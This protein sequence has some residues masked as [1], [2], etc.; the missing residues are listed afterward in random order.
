MQDMQDHSRISKAMRTIGLFWR[1]IRLVWDASPALTALTLALALLTAVTVPVQVWI[2]KV[3][4]DRIG[5]LIGQGEGGSWQGLMLPLALYIGVWGISQ[6]AQS[7]LYSVR[8]LLNKQTINHTQYRIIQKAA[9]LDAAFF[10][11][12][13]FYDQM[14]VAGREVWRLANIIYQGSGFIIFLV[15]M[16]SL[17]ILLGSI[18]PVLPAVLVLA[19]LPKIISEGHFTRKVSELMMR[20]VPEERMIDYV[21]ALLTERETV[22]EVRLFQLQ[23]HLLDRHRRACQQYFRSLAA[24][25]LS[26][27]RANS[28]FTLLSLISTAGIWVWAGVQALAGRISLGDI[29]LIF[30]SVERSRLSLD[31]IVIM[32]GFLVENTVYLNALFGYLDLEPGTVAGTLSRASD[33]GQVP[34][35]DL[36]GPIEFRGVS[37][38]YAGADRDALKDITFTIQPGEKVALVGENGAG[39]TTLV[40][41]LTRLYDPTAGEV[42]VNGR[43]LRS[44]DQARYYRRIGVIFQDFARYS[45]TAKEN[46]GLGCVEA[47]G[48]EDRIRRAARL[49][50]AAELIES[51]PHGYETMLN[52]RFEGGMDLSGGEWQKVALSRAF[53]RDAHLL[54]LDEPT[55]AL[56]A[57]A[58]SEV[59]QRFADLTRG[60]T[61]VFVTHRLSSVHMADKILVLKN[62]RLV[63][64]GN[65]DSLMALQGEYASMFN[66]QAEH[67]R[68]TVRDEA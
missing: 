42:T 10:D 65:H 2:S 44:L 43:D 45:L 49:G 57:F 51:L 29:A 37:F 19:A 30:Q 59:Y 68:S 38:R 55:A 24:I 17:F 1:A 50:G 18:S 58:E 25:V 39:K 63:E 31:Q 16:S 53:M 15:S 64:E 22:K 52:K 34:E 33:P 28:L 56:D 40:K 5:A 26:K 35:L 11:S 20:R 27:E 13:T 23:G 21:S 12:P 8:E 7:V 67:Y 3:M 47:L 66:L 62:G 32:G 6:V 9:A 60:K 48:D 41:L 14:S 36:S 54:I 61:T 46:V 4:I